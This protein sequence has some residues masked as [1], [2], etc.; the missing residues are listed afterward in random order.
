MH[1]WKDI[2]SNVIN[3]TIQFIDLVMDVIIVMQALYCDYHML[4]Q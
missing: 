1:N 2:Q 4:E 3:V